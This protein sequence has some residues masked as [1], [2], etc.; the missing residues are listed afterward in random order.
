[1]LSFESHRNSRASSPKS[2]GK[3][4]HRRKRVSHDALRD[5]RDRCIEALKR[6]GADRGT[7]CFFEK[8]MILLTRHWAKVP[9]SGRADLLQ[10]ADWLIR[11]GER[12]SLPA[13]ANAAHISG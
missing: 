4:C 5:G 8:A 13:R 6:L 9:W 12:E 7:N 3:A 1:M 2:A 10:T 11:V